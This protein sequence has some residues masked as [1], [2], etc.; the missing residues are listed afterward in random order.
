MAGGQLAE[1]RSRGDQLPR[2]HRRARP[3]R[4]WSAARRGGRSTPP[5]G[6]PARP[7]NTTVPRPRGVHRLARRLRPGRRRGG[8]AA[9]S[10]TARRTPAQPLV[11]AATASPAGRRRP[12]PAARTASATAASHTRVRR[13]RPAQRV[14]DAIGKA[15]AVTW[16]SALRLWTKHLLGPCKLISAIRTSGLTSRACTA[17]PF[18]QGRIRM[19][20][21][22]EFGIS[23]RVRHAADARARHHPTP[24]DNRQ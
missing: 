15:R 7:A 19:P 2:P 1:H 16:G 10:A 6:R 11:A 20:G 14:C 12:A 3:A 9:N 17:A 8:R 23:D 4:S 22:P 5:A 13:I 18:L 24:D 21:G